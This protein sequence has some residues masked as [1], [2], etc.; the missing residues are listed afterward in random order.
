M[1]LWRWR[2]A[3]AEEAGAWSQGL[4]FDDSTTRQLNTVARSLAL[5]RSGSN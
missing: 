5:G 4:A 2:F 1:L 3:G